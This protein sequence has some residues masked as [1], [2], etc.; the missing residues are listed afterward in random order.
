MIVSFHSITTVL[1]CS[2]SAELCWPKMF[3]CMLGVVNAGR[4]LILR[5][6]CAVVEFVGVRVGQLP[7]Q[8]ALKAC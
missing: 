6:V 3:S 8:W 4:F 7:A 5:C 1:L 2:N